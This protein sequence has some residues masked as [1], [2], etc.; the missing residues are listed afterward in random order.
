VGK[1]ELWESSG[2]LKL[3]R[4]VWNKAKKSWGLVDNSCKSTWGEEKLIGAMQK[5]RIRT[6]KPGSKEAKASIISL[7]SKKL[8][9]EQIKK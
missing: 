4:V 2:D 9:E 7:R 3:I 1:M 8:R 6:R 5:R